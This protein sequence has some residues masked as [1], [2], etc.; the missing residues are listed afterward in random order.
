[1]NF[2]PS[3]N[4]IQCLP[5]MMPHRA[6][7]ND[8]PDVGQALGNARSSQHRSGHGSASFHR[9]SSTAEEQRAHRLM[10]QDSRR[11]SSMP[12]VLLPA[13]LF[14]PIDRVSRP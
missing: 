3:T 2:A 1:M 9:R 8:V 4:T 10:L 14:K 11:I 6:D 5:I 13:D 12:K 7:S